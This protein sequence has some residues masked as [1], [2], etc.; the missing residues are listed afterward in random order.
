MFQS[1][2]HLGGP[3]L[4]F[5]QYV[6]VFLVL[7]AP[8]LDMVLWVW[9]HQSWVER[10]DCFSLPAGNILLVQPRIPLAFLSARAHSWLNFNL[11]YTRS[12]SSF[13]TELPSSW[14]TPMA[15]SAPCAGLHSSLYWT[16]CNSSHL[17]YPISQ[18]SLGCLHSALVNQPHN[19]L[20]CNL[21]F[22]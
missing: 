10:K 21:V 2:D 18:G 7:R 13:S 16:P 12:S 20:L 3:T 19:P 1:S 9:P 4:D 8:E 11:V 14:M 22:Y 15:C 17:N 5:F 6:N